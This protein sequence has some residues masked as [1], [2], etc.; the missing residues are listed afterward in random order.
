[1]SQICPFTLLAI[2][3][4]F[5]KFA[6]PKSFSSDR[7]RVYSDI[8]QL[9]KY[10]DIQ[11]YNNATMHPDI[12]RLHIDDGHHEPVIRTAD[13][14]QRSAFYSGHS[15]ARDITSEFTDASAGMFISCFCISL[16]GRKK[17]RACLCLCLCFAK[18]WPQ[19]V[20]WACWNKYLLQIA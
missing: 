11:H 5:T 8:R 6:S 12:A 3:G 14:P 15:R 4:Q 16:N 7:R 20:F 19:H 17:K 9:Q 10:T 2:Y 18:A 1:M 13:N